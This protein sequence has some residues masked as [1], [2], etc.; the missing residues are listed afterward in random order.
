MD[1]NIIIDVIENYFCETQ[2]KKN[3]V[4]CLKPHIEQ[5]FKNNLQRTFLSQLNFIADF[6]GSHRN[7]IIFLASTNENNC[8]LRFSLSIN[9][10]ELLNSEEFS[11][12]VEEILL[13]NFP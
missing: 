8:T 12:A 13:Q 1:T 3:D 7:N 2:T 10:Q 5:F 9:I 6:V 11:T 4:R